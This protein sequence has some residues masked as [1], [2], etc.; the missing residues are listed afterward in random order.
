LRAGMITLRTFPEALSA[1]V[2]SP[3]PAVFSVN[4]S[5]TDPLSMAPATV[6]PGATTPL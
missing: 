4:P 5:V 2:C 6:N 1:P 3:L